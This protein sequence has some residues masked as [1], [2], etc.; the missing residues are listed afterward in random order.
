M[1]GDAR[2]RFQKD[3]Q[4][5]ASH[6]GACIP[7]ADVQHPLVTHKYDL[8]RVLIEIE[9][10]MGDHGLAWEIQDS[11]TDDGPDERFYLAG[12]KAR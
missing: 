11:G 4:L 5:R 3:G 2:I 8:A 6:D 12:W 10:C 9:L 7:H 1:S